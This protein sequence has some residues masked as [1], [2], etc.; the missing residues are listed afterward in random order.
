MEEPTPKRTIGKAILRFF[1]RFL[2]LVLITA[3]VLGAVGLGAIYVTVRG[4]STA[5]RNYFVHSVK[6]TSA[7]GFLADIFF[8]LRRAPGSTLLPHAALVRSI[9]P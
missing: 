4:E 7:I 1:L 8:R 2:L 5:A 9:A 6:E 3:L